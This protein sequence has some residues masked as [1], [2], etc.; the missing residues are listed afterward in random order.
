MK[1]WFA[2]QTEDEMGFLDDGAV[3]A[4]GSVIRPRRK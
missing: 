4:D 2:L 1:R 3:G